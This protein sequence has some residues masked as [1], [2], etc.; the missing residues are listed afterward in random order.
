MELHSNTQEENTPLLQQE[1]TK[2]PK[3]SGLC[4][5]KENI[6]IGC[7][8]AVVSITMVVLVVLFYI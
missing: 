8:C 3:N 6:V 4:F 2:D 5:S 7:I 1:I